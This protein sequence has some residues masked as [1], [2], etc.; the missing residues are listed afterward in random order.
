LSATRMLATRSPSCNLSGLSRSVK[1][2][3]K[4]YASASRTQFRLDLS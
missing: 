4:T 3:M 2:D 1:P